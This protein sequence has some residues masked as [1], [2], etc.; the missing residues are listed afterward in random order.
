MSEPEVWETCE[1]DDEEWRIDS[2]TCG[3]DYCIW[4]ARWD[5]PTGDGEPEIWCRECHL[6]DL[7]PA[8]WTTITDFQIQVHATTG[9][10]MVHLGDVL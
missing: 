7:F 10:S 4:L 1:S 5:D 6:T 2:S 8:S 3:H 9:S